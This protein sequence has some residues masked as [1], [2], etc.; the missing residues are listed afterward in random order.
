[1]VAGRT[2]AS[3]E[4]SGLLRNLIDEGREQGFVSLDEV[5]AALPDDFSDG[6]GLDDLIGEF[7]SEGLELVEGKSANRSGSMG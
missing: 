7:E 3:Q 4:K 1:M 2:V 6:A 5:N